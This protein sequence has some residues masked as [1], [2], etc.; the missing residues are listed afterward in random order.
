[1]NDIQTFQVAPG[2]EILWL[3]TTKF[4]VARLEV[5]FVTE[6]ELTSTTSRRLLAN[7][8]QR[9]SA[10]WPKESLLSRQLSS[11]YGAELTAKTTILQNLNVLS[12]AISA[13]VSYDNEEIFSAAQKLL[14]ECLLHPNA[15]QTKKQF[16]QQ[17]FQIE[18]TNL[19]NAYASIADNYS[20]Q[21]SLDLQKL[22]YQNY[23]ELAIPVFGTLT[24]LQQVSPQQLWQQYQTILQTNRIIA[25]L[26]GDVDQSII[27]QLTSYLQQLK[28]RQQA[29]NLQMKSLRNFTEE[30]LVQQRQE[31][32]QQSQ[33]AL[34]YQVP[35]R[36]SVLQVLNMML[37]G[38]DQ[39][40]LFQKVREQAGLAYSIYSNVNSYQQIISIYAGIS[41]EKL[42]QTKQIISQQ[43]ATLATEQLE[44]LLQHAKLALINQRLELADSIAT[45]ANQLLLKALNPRIMI[46][47]E[48]YLQKIQQ[49]SLQDI[50]QAASHLHEIAEFCLLGTEK[51]KKKKVNG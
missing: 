46:D 6:Q 20:L 34:A 1:M 32:I 19:A 25:T 21:A 27:T 51:A 43:I 26:V 35:A 9:S 39:S 12:L 15:N 50:H 28:A 40:L 31:Q 18:Q 8:L 37:G 36:K 38:D 10:A 48:H 7:M 13:P 3:P 2:V 45:P 4:H 11:L 16:S 17:A 33:L 5:N 44:D 49:V 22:I 29:V 14:W 24:Q 23:P 42:A 41:A 30:P 47:D